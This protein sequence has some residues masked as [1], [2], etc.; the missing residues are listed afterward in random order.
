MAS[1]EPGPTPAE[2]VTKGRLVGIVLAGGAS[3]RFG[4]DK[5]G[6][7]L[8]GGSLVLHVLDALYRV[9]VDAVVLAGPAEP[10]APA[11]LAAATGAGARLVRDPE[12]FV[13]PLVAVSNA[14]GDLDGDDVALV[15]A[16]DMPWLEP[17]LLADLARAA[18]EPGAVAA[19][20]VVDGRDEPLP[21]ALRVAPG[22]EAARAL[23][24]DGVRR[25]G[26]LLEALDRGLRRLPVGASAVR[27]VDTAADM[28]PAGADEAPAGGSDGAALSGPGTGRREAAV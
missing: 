5:L 6:A 3:R 2:L 16:G 22:R 20:L 10:A 17:A 28:E 14:L 13:G 9:P 26:A 12:P 21:L 1:S 7:E 27:D 25:L 8:A 4:S 11:W 24:D 15:V 23:V 19:S 18:S